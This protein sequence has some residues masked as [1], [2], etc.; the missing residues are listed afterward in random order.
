MYG[1]EAKQLEEGSELLLCGY[2]ACVAAC[3]KYAIIGVFLQN[4]NMC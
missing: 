2:L 1:E 3:E 4:S